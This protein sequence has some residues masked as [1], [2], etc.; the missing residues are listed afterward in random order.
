MCVVSEPVHDPPCNALNPCKGTLVEPVTNCRRRPLLSSL[1]AS[2]ACQNH[3]T[4]LLSL[5]QCFRRVLVFQ[6]ARSI[7]PSPPMINW[8]RGRRKRGSG[9]RLRRSKGGPW[10]NKWRLRKPHNKF[11]WLP[12]CVPKTRK[13]YTTTTIA[14]FIDYLLGYCSQAEQVPQVLYGQRV[15]GGAGG[16]AHWIP[17]VEPETGLQFHA[18]TSSSHK[19]WK[20]Q[21][22]NDAGQINIL[23]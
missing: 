18:W 23:W 17:S 10:H 3:R 20:T 19:V 6:S 5:V 4:T 7:F 12:L 14:T 9:K 11:Y 16:W 1:K 15:W 8:S 21:N 2:T 13:H 22:T